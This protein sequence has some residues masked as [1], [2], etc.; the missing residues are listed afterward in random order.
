MHTTESHLAFALARTHGIHAAQIIRIDVGLQSDNFRIESDVGTFFAK[1]YRPDADLDYERANLETMATAAA[2]G[3]PVLAPLQHGTTVLAEF[4]GLPVAVWKWCDGA[5]SGAMNETE[6]A[7]AAATLAQLHLYLQNSRSA[8]PW[9][10]PTPHYLARSTEDIRDRLFLLGRHVRNLPHPTAW[11]IDNLDRIS[12]RLGYLQ[13]VPA[14]LAE[15]GHHRNNVIHGDFV[16]PNIILRSHRVAGVIDFRIR[17]DD[18]RRELA[19]LV[20][21]VSTVAR[22]SNWLAVALSALTAYLENG[23]VVQPAHILS[24]ARLALLHS[25]CST[26][27]LDEFYSN[28]NPKTASFIQSYWNDE[29]VAVEKLLQRLPDIDSAVIEIAKVSN[30]MH[31]PILWPCQPRGRVSSHDP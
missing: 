15:I 9:P 6:A 10:L 18:A 7:D 16:R 29:C 28:A 1:V 2:A 26:L 17:L 11:D 20:F 21:D 4:D 3:L 30:P 27:P 22:Q 25:C 23:G 8:G 13:H 31:Q 14:L 12:Q 5:T 19:R 24:C